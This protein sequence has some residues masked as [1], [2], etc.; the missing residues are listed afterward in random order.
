MST[1]SKVS[2]RDKARA[3]MAEQR[4]AQ[5]ARDQATEKDLATLLSA[6]DVIAKARDTQAAAVARAQA[7]YDKACGA[8]REAFDA[9]TATA[10]ADQA[11]AAVAM[12]HRGDTIA[13][14][15]ALAEMSARDVT[16]LI[17]T[18]T[19]T[20]PAAQTDSGD[21]DSGTDTPTPADADSESEASVGEALGEPG[22]DDT[23]PV[24]AD[25]PLVDAGVPAS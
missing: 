16:A 3:K 20:P 1:S 12:K 21:G 13:T 14:I 8:A 15:A 24:T 6:D 19:S 23:D 10:R 22:R 4:E 5:R 17:K 9:A 25:Q 18:H 11:A 2:A 7:V